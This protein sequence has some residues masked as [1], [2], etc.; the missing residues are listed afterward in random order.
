MKKIDFDSNSIKLG[1]TI[2]K[3]PYCIFKAW[4]DESIGY[5]I[6]IM[7]PNANSTVSR[8]NNIIAY[9]INRHIKTIWTAELPTSSGPDCYWDLEADDDNLSA[10]SYSCF[11]CKLDIKTGKIISKSFTK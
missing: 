7:D 4:Y 9:E 6:V 11:R 5:V 3:V 8:F 10:F 2:I 1:E